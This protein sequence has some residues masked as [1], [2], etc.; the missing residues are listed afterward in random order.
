MERMIGVG[1]GCLASA[2]KHPVNTSFQ[3]L[4]P[5]FLL[6][7]LLAPI[8]RVVVASPVLDIL[9]VHASTVVSNNDAVR[10]LRVVVLASDLMPS[11]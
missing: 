10:A 2:N 3:A 6:D 5:P 1:Q 9:Q 4:C 8:E 11:T 7:S